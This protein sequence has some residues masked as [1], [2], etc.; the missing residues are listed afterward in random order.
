MRVVRRACR[1]VPPPAG[2]SPDP[3]QSGP[4]SRRGV[5][6]VPPPG[7]GSPKGG[8]APQPLPRSRGS[9]GRAGSLPAPPASRRPGSWPI[10]RPPRRSGPALPFPVCGSA[11]PGG[12]VPGGVAPAE[13]R[14]PALARETPGLPGPPGRSGPPPRARCA[15]ARRDT[16]RRSQPGHLR[17]EIC[18]PRPPNWPGSAR[19]E[20]GPRK[21]AARV[22]AG[23]QKPP[24]GFPSAAAS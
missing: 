4:R 18:P 15:H 12:A 6:G 23:R 21:S 22:G 1:R 14:R 5:P 8:S 20:P 13:R 11:V 3:S 19:R 10:H 9:P 24:Q 17:E 7:D 16:P 2:R